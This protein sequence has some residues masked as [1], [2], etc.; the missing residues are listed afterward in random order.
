MTEHQGKQALEGIRVLDFTQMMLGPLCTQT[1]ADL[2]ADV[3]KIE[4]PG[5]GEWMRSMPMI[6]QLVGGDSAAFHSFNRNKR[7]VTVDLKSPEGRDALIEMASHCDVVVENFRSGVM[8]RLG[9][10]YDDFSAANPRIIYASGSGWGAGSYLAEKGWPGQDLLVQAM[11]G[12]MFNT[13]RAGDPPTACG[14]PIAD[15]AASQA[16]AIGI[17]GALLARD[18]HGVGQKVETNLY[19]ATLNLMGQENFAVLNQGIELN[20]SEAGVASCWNDAPYGACPTADGWIA[21]AMCPLETLAELLGDEGLADL[22]PWSQ[23]DETKQRIDA[24]TSKRTTAELMEIFEAADVW[25]APIRNS[26]EALDELVALDSPRLVE[27]D[28]PK[29]G[30]IKAIAN[31]ITMSGTPVSLRFVPPQVGEHTDEV[32]GEML[33]SEVVEKLRAAGAL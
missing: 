5:K 10:G 13:G 29:A 4:R 9:L 14:T 25:A 22:D 16:L 8:D 12:V 18:R 17:L 26:K 3:I 27:M 30:K 24:G 21:I 31:P 23:R 20:R 28:H 32:L 7:S 6:G 15:F 11:S 1:L 2:G 33:G 19:S